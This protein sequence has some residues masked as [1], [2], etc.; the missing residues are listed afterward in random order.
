MALTLKEQTTLLT[1]AQ[2]AKRIKF[3]VETIK[4]WTYR[5]VSGWP[6]PM[7][8]GPQGEWRWREVDILRWVKGQPVKS[9]RGDNIAHVGSG[10][11][12]K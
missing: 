1:I 4:K 2:V 7:R 9:Q 12:R 10:K 3:S 11:K 6:Q 5:K 8:C